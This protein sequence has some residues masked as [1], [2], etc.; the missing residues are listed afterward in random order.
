M[1]NCWWVFYRIYTPPTP[2]H[3]RGIA[4][5]CTIVCAIFRSVGIILC[6]NGRLHTTVDFFYSVP[7][8][9]IPCIVLHFSRYFQSSLMRF[10]CWK[11]SGDTGN[12]HVTHCTWF[13]QFSNSLCIISLSSCI[14]TVL[15]M[16]SPPMSQLLSLF[17]D[18]SFLLLS[19]VLVT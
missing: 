3:T 16:F 1:I 10:F 19:K 8:Q 12:T 7:L 17:V 4:F 6:E 13:V 15:S 9:N 2:F 18:V 14:T 11:F 5:F